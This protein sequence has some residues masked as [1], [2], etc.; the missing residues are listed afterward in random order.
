MSGKFKQLAVAILILTATACN[1]RAGES[2]STPALATTAGSS[3]NRTASLLEL[4]NIVQARSSATAEWSVATEGQQLSVGGGVKTGEAS[5][6]RI[7]ISGGAIVRLAAQ[8]E[9]SL[10]ELS[11]QAVD[12]VTKFSLLPRWRLPLPRAR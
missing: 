3:A 5:R 2:P 11:L 8:S 6:V 4:K 1:T 9:F 12:P 7:N 10:D